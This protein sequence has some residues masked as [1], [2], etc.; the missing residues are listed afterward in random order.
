MDNVVE[1]YCSVDD[2]M[3]EFWVEWIKKLLTSG[4]KKR[5]KPSKLSTSEVMTIMILFHRSNYRTLKH[6]YLGYVCKHMQ[7]YFPKLVGYSQFVRLEQSVLIPLCSYLNS[8][9]GRVTGISYVD[10]TTIKV[11]HNKR[12]YRN[13]VFSGLAARGKSTM[14]WFYG[15]KLHIIINEH[16]DLLSFCITKGNVDDRKPLKKITKNII[17][18]LFGDRGY[19]S[20]KHFE[21]LMAN[22]LQLITTIKKNMKNKLMPMIDKILLRKRYLIETINDQLKN[23]SQIE[24]SR[25]R[26]AANFMV[27]M[28]AGLIAYTHQPKKPSLNFTQNIQSFLA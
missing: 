8:R 24:H 22:G 10:S 27:N 25:H 4:E 11:C 21:E 28:I 15:F 18:K 16:G 12:I 19:I 7:S 9:K 2:F 20:K 13:K 1:I 14:G 3:K 17:G 6:F 23:I 26:S 5:N